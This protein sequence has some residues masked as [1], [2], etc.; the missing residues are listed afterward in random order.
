[1]RRGRQVAEFARAV[2]AWQN[3][4]RSAS[5]D[6]NV[7]Q[8]TAAPDKQGRTASHDCGDAVFR[9]GHATRVVSQYA[10]IGVGLERT[11]LADRVFQPGE[12]A[13]GARG[14]AAKKDRRAPAAS[15]PPNPTHAPSTYPQ[16]A[17]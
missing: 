4:R 1:G 15:A 6:D 10:G 2:E 5:G 13:A 9:S 14:G 7:V 16:R 8:R 11:G 12:Y 17:P 3:N